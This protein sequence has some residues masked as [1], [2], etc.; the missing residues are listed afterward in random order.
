MVM[1]TVM[2]L[3]VRREKNQFVR[4]AKSTGPMK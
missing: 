4:L 3:N 1:N 2:T